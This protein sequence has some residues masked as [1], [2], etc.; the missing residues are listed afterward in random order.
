ML[1]SV[2][3]YKSIGSERE[4]DFCGLTILAGANSSG[5]SSFMQPLLILKQTLESYIATNV[6][7]IDGPNLKLTDSSQILSKVKGH[8]SKSFSIGYRSKET[9]FKALY[10][11]K[12][13]IGFSIEKQTY[14]GTDFPNGL[15]LKKNSTDEGIRNQ[16]GQNSDRFPFNFIKESNS[17]LKAIQDRSFIDVSISPEGSESSGFAFAFSPSGR[18]SSLLKKMI[19]VPGLR[20]NPER[21]YRATAFEGNFIGSFEQYVASIIKNWKM[22]DAGKKKPN[23]KYNELVKQL[24]LL[25]LAQSIDARSINDTR[26][27]LVVSRIKKCTQ[28]QQR[29]HI[30]IDTD[31]VSIADVGFGVSQTL[32]VLVALLTA[33]K[34]NLVYI[35]QPEL[36][37]HPNAQFQLAGIVASAVKRGVIVVIETHSSIFL[38]GIQT[39]VAKNEIDSNKISLNW[40]SQ[41]ERTGNTKIDKSKMDSHGAFGD[42]PSD[43]DDVNMMVESTYLDA[44][45]AS[46]FSQESIKND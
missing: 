14:K 31:L 11:L 3:G 25:G 7:T 38:R 24:Q 19:H 2:K 37:L 13:G 41:D 4:I 44:V 35:E 5:K 20:G 32:P 10:T 46:I 40:F 9:E 16:I 18:I 30:A 42:W 26:I 8:E 21:T 6:L 43:F 17:K 12:Q 15:T 22:I 28:S 36:H 1:I 45:E 27:E 29:E 34:G 23:S 39:C 33:E